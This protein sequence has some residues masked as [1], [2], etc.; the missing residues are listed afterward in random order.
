[1]NYGDILGNLKA[2]VLRGDITTDLGSLNDS[3]GVRGTVAR[4]WNGSG[5]IVGSSRIDRFGYHADWVDVFHA[6]LWD[7]G[8][9]RDLGVLRPN[10]CQNIPG[11]TD[12]SWAEATG[13]SADGVVV[14]TS[15][16]DSLYRAFIWENGEMRDLGVFPGHYTQALTINDRG[17]VLGIVGHTYGRDTTFFWDDGH[18][19][20][21]VPNAQR[22]SPV[23][24]PNGEVIGA[25][26][27][28]GDSVAHAFFW[29]GGQLT[30]LGRGTAVAVNS[31]G[32][33]LGSRGFI[34]TLWRK[35]R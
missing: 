9:M 27:V 12:C 13:I 22:P 16:A 14:G 24:G 8:V 25:M 21:I 3:L 18:V 33:I 34:P 28:A 2:V 26:I 1:V 4:A 31:R 11:H 30:D 23:L 10:P 20:I 29:Q 5:Q 7:N 15:G 17:Q 19:Q 35:K 6:F 32:E